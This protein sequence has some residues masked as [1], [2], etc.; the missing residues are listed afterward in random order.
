VLT[1]LQGAA[2]QLVQGQLSGCGATP[3]AATLALD[4]KVW[5]LLQHVAADEVQVFET[6]VDPAINSD[7][8]K[9]K[10]NLCFK[11]W[12]GNIQCVAKTDNSPNSTATNSGYMWNETQNWDVG[13]N[14]T[15]TGAVTG[16]PANF[17]VTGNGSR[18]F[19]SGSVSFT[20][21]GRKQEVLSFGVTT[22]PRFSTPI[23]ST[24]AITE[25]NSSTPGSDEEMQV[26][27]DPDPSGDTA[28]RDDPNG[29][30]P[31][32]WTIPNSCVNATLNPCGTCC[33]VGCTW[34]LL[35]QQ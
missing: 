26:K 24:S 10:C 34:D 21:D 15:T 27:F 28:K 17:T 20:I 7:A 11:G 29:T 1:L 35:N 25:S 12:V 5:V 19:N 22:V 4:Q 31:P 6:Y 2:S 30:V 16:Y 9:P 8:C 14:P 32:T 13:G 18:Q 23:N 33:T 3:A